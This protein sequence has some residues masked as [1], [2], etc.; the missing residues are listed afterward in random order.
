[1]R[2]LSSRVPETDGRVLVL[3]AQ[4]VRG[5]RRRSV[6]DDPKVSSIRVHSTPFAS[7]R[8][9]SEYTGTKSKR[10][11]NLDSAIDSSWMEIAVFT[12]LSISLQATFQWAATLFRVYQRRGGSRTGSGTLSV[13]AWGLNPTVQFPPLQRHS[14]PLHDIL[15]FLEG[16]CEWWYVLPSQ[17]KCTVR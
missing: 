9:G 4:L 1:M 14:V 17:R 11:V 5:G 2:M 6:I 3:L 16:Q 13:E 15:S 10:G 12:R 7:C 8:L